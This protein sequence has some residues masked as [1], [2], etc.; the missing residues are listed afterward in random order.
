MRDEEL[1][2]LLR[3]RFP[4]AG[5]ASVEVQG[6]AVVVRTSRPGVLMGK[7]GAIAE[8]LTAELRQLR[9]PLT[10]LQLVQIS[11]PELEAVL[12][13]DHVAQSLSSGSPP[14]RIID[15]SAAQAMK[16]GAAGC[17]IVVTGAFEYQATRGVLEGVV[18]RASVK[19]VVKP[20]FE[21][22]DDGNEVPPPPQ[23]GPLPEFEVQVS[24]SRPPG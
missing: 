8:Q 22:D 4:R 23:T 15:L 10:E 3:S 12:V 17:L 16:V 9:G 11:R 18:D 14:P 2:T 24:L 7:Q 6:N 19:G 13:A 5:V 20:P 21:V 1:F